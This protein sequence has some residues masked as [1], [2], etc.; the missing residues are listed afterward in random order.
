MG[1]GS[2]LVVGVIKAGLGAKQVV[3]TVLHPVIAARNY[4]LK[5]I[6]RAVADRLKSS[7]S[8]ATDADKPASRLNAAYQKIEKISK[9]EKQMSYKISLSQL[10][11]DVE[12]VNEATLIGIDISAYKNAISDFKS[13]TRKSLFNFIIEDDFSNVNT[14]V[15]GVSEVLNTP[16]ELVG[17]EL[18]S[19]T[20]SVENI[21]IHANDLDLN[22]NLTLKMT[23]S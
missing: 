22:L 13:N 11:E 8:T 3:D 6:I 16:T 20:A 4:I 23:S 2:K 1:I 10:I 5:L 19:L 14:I 17:V 21:D 12:H 7:V 18:A 9:T 15:E